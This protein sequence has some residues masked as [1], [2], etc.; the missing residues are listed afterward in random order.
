LHEA[1]QSVVYCIVSK[2]KKVMA[3]VALALWGLA[4]MHCDLEHVPG[5]KFLAWCHSPDAAAKQTSDDGCCV[6][7]SALYKVEQHE[8]V[9]PMPVLALSLLLPAWEMTSALSEPQPVRLDFSPAELPRL[10]QFF[11]RTALPPRAPSSIA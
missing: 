5:L 4:T 8:V 3:V 7:E 9:V 1:S 6:V 2:L 10:W 11:Y